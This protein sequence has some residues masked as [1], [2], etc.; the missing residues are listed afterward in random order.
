MFLALARV[1][2]ATRIAMVL[3]R[4]ALP[5]RKSRWV[6]LFGMSDAG[7]FLPARVLSAGRSP[8]SSGSTTNIMMALPI[9]ARLVVT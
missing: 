6:R 4:K 1:E 5:K 3:S 2:S 9:E 8:K 7:L